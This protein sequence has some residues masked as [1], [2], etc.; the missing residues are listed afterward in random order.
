MVGCNRTRGIV[1]LLGSRAFWCGGGCVCRNRLGIRGAVL[2][3]SILHLFIDDK[4]FNWSMLLDLG[5][6]RLRKRSA[7]I[8]VWSLKASEWTNLAWQFCVG[9]LTIALSESHKLAAWVFTFTTPTVYQTCC[10]TTPPAHF[11][12]TSETT[13]FWATGLN[14]LRPHC[15]FCTFESLWRGR[16][17]LFGSLSWCRR[18]RRREEAA[19]LVS[20]ECSQRSFDKNTQIQLTVSEIQTSVATFQPPTSRNAVLGNVLIAI[21]LVLLFWKRPGHRKCGW[22]G[23]GRCGFWFRGLIIR[24]RATLQVFFVACPDFSHL[25]S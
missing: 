17:L 4:R 18:S 12:L 1:R 14:Q 22:I 11:C 5:H 8:K 9:S 23:K 24:T 21:F 6:S 10:G 20:A 2:L 25:Y 13:R 15:N 16:A 19:L 7:V 3:L